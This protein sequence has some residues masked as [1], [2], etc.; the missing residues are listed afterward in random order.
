MTTF[1]LVNGGAHGGWCWELVTPELT[2]MGH[3]SVAPDLPIED[4]DADLEDWA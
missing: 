1:A 4:D 3:T 2:G